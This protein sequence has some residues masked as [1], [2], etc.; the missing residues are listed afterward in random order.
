MSA[1]P[2][3]AFDRPLTEDEAAE[4][5]GVKPVTLTFWRTRKRGPAFIKL[6]GLVRYRRADLE[7]FVK[8]A[9]VRK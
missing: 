6:G 4:L 2:Q 8:N 1:K 9:A 3:A 5:I 7:A